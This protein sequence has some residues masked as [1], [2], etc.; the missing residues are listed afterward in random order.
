MFRM[1]VWQESEKVKEHCAG[2]LCSTFVVKTGV[3]Y[4]T[5]WFFYYAFRMKKNIL[6]VAYFRE[7]ALFLIFVFQY[8]R[9][10]TLS[11][12]FHSSDDKQVSLTPT[13]YKKNHEKRLSLPI[14]PKLTSD[15]W[16][17]STCKHIP[18]RVRAHIYRAWNIHRTLAAYRQ[19]KKTKIIPKYR[20]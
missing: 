5:I 14:M 20:K 4:T 11:T 10:K 7:K 16:F 3:Y 17:S 2:A 19:R 6:W 15:N 1:C 9:D 18:S 13:A 8:R 12:K